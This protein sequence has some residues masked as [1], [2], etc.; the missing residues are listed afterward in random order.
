MT[1]PRTAAISRAVGRLIVAVG[2]SA[3][4]PQDLEDLQLL[5]RRLAAAWKVAVRGLRNAGHTD[6]DIAL[7]IGCSE[8]DVEARWP[9]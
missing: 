8:Q 3:R 9:R 1:A 7:A 6:S 2:A 5:D 4:S